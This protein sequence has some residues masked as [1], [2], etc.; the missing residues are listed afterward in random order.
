MGNVTVLPPRNCDPEV[1]Q[2]MDELSKLQTWLV[3][4]GARQ[5]GQLEMSA[6]DLIQRTRCLIVERCFNP[7]EETSNG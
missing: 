5:G 4:Q 6:A 7:T 3:L 2:I 1:A